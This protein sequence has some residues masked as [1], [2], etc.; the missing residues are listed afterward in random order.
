MSSGNSFASINFN[1]PKSPNIFEKHS[2][3]MCSSYKK[4][5]GN[6]FTFNLKLLKKKDEKNAYIVSGKLEYPNFVQKYYIKYNGANPPNYNS[7]FSGSGLPF[8]NE[9]I[10]FE[11]TPNRG[12]AEIVNGDFKFVIK[13][14]NSY[15][16]NMGTIYIPPQVRMVIVDK[17]NKELSKILTL[18]LGEGIPFRTLTWPKQRNW[19]EGSLFYNNQTL[20][21]R[22][23]YQI[24]LDSAYPSKNVM[25]K[26]F[27]GM[28]YPH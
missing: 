17:D 24:L 2:Q 22:S 7:T 4:S 13:Y 19:N 28:V 27:W 26:N 25:P 16:T 18:N 3:E 6:D 9:D 5:N 14:P 15:Y 8:P 23:Q 12:V 11:N 21:V 10:A 20:P 1:D